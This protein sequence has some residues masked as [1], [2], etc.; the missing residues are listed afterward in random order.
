VVVAAVVVA[1]IVVVEVAAV[2]V[3]A[4]A[5]IAV[6]VSPTKAASNQ[7]SFASIAAPRSS[8]AAGLSASGP[9]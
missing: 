8:R 2:V 6:T 3:V 7:P 5:V 9:W 4:R 1:M